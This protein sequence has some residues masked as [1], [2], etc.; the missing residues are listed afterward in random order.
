ME[1]DLLYNNRPHPKDGEGTVF[2]D[3]CMLAG[4]YPMVS[5]PRSL[6]WS[7]ASGSFR[8]VPPVLQPRTGSNLTEYK[9]IGLKYSGDSEHIRNCP[10]FT[11]YLVRPSPCFTDHQF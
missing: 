2:T 7:L 8:G 6:P 9:C 3:V 10:L 11:D 1:Q 5:G 4:R